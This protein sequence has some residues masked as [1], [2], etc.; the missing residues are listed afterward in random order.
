MVLEII[1][2]GILSGLLGNWIADYKIVDR[3]SSSQVIRP[4]RPANWKPVSHQELLN[5]CAVAC[6][7]R[8]LKRYSMTYG[9]CECRITKGEANDK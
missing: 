5:Q 6:G 8:N 4:D 1:L 9:I 3:D 7:E 2:I